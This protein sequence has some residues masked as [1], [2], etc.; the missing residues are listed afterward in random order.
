MRSLR[1]FKF[2]Q[3]PQHV[4]GSATTAV[5]KVYVVARQIGDEI[6]KVLRAHAHSPLADKDP[7]A[8]ESAKDRSKNLKHL[9]GLYPG[10]WRVRERKKRES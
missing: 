2:D 9:E 5:S 7:E 3:L 6:D 8:Q 1:N 4:K 10:S